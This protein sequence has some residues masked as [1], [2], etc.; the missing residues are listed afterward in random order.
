MFELLSIA[1][2]AAAMGQGDCLPGSEWQ[3]TPPRPDAY[4]MQ[5][6]PGE[7]Q[8]SYSGDGHDF[9]PAF[10]T[11]H[12]R[13]R[14]ALICAGDYRGGPVVQVEYPEPGYDSMV[15]ILPLSESR[16]YNV[17]VFGVAHCADASR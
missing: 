13:R 9:E 16:T 8:L 14:A 2:A 15:S 11:E 1:C 7:Y 12:W 4:E 5:V 6:A 3:P 17:Q 10:L